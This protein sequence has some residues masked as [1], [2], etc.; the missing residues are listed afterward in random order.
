M[1]LKKRE[2]SKEIIDPDEPIH[3]PEIRSLVLYITFWGLVFL[4]LINAYYDRNAEIEPEYKYDGVYKIS[5]DRGS[6]HH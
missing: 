5:N 2:K 3:K 1:S 4:I 6:Q